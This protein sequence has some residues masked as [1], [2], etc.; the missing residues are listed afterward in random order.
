VNLEPICLC[1]TEGR[2]E[3]VLTV[4]DC[5]PRVNIML[6]GLEG[7]QNDAAMTTWWVFDAQ[8]TL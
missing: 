8:L 3:R 4:A 5:Q 6:P 1:R 2:T 7:R